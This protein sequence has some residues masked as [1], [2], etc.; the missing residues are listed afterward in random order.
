MDELKGLAILMVVIYHAGGVLGWSNQF[1]A[2]LGVDIFVILSGIGLTI[3]GS[4]PGAGPFLWRRL[5]RIF[6]AYWIALGLFLWLNATYLDKHYTAANIGLHILGIH[7]WFGDAYAVAINDSFWFIT[8][9]LTL[10]LLFIGLERWRHQPER[11]LLA[12]AIISVGVIFAYQIAGQPSVYRHIGLRLPGFF[13]G[14]VIGNLLRTGRV[15]AQLG[16]ALA[17]AFFIVAYVPSLR[18][19]ILAS[20][21]TGLAVMGFYAFVLRRPFDRATEGAIPRVLTFLGNHSLEIFLLHQP[22]IRDF[23]IVVQLRVLKRPGL[24]PESLII[25]MVIAF[26]VTLVLSELLQR[27][28]GRLLPVKALAAP[29]AD[30]GAH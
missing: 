12:G 27:L 2:D 18:G 7:A 14:M 1:Q 6:P 16:A 17:A 19:I 30:D 4:Y 29:R 15:S 13:I 11:L 20:T 8:L 5:V 22:L 25:G 28:L 9:I 23:N 10:Y 26:L 3:G 21:I 24:T